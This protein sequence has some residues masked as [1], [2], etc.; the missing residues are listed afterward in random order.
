MGFKA[1]RN[2]IV[3]NQKEFNVKNNLPDGDAVKTKNP[4]GRLSPP[5]HIF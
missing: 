5:F 4:T 3:F 1:N 2:R